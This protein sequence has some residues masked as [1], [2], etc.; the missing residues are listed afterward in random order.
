MIKLPVT[1][2]Q[3]DIYRFAQ[4]IRGEI[5]PQKPMFAELFLDEGMIKLIGEEFLG[6][7]WVAPK[8]DRE[9]KK[10]YW[11]FKIRVYHALGYDYL[12]MFGAPVFP[13]RPRSQK[14]SRVWAE[15]GKGPIQSFDDF[16]DYPWPELTD[17]MLW[18]YYYVSE[19]LPD[20]MGMFVANGD[21]FLEVVANILIGYE[22]MCMMLYDDEALLKAVIEKAGGIIYDACSKMIH[23]PKSAGVFIGDD[24]G[25]GTSMLFSPE[26]Y[27]EHILPW[28]KKLAQAVHDENQLYLLHSCG[29]NDA[30]MRDL[31]DD[32]KIDAKHSFQEGFY[33]VREYKQKYGSEVTLLG[34]VDVNLL[35]TLDEEEL[36]KYVRDILSACM[37][38]GRYMLGTGNSV[39]DYIPVKNY[40]AMLD[41]G[42]KFSL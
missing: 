18:D 20:G 10:K 24:M 42:L 14:G 16:Y 30:I 12:W 11:D 19:N 1:N 38:G 29:K 5:I 2:P 25:F 31:I 6:M 39:T 27:R 3:P 34:G 33:G 8:A 40:F 9:S 35:C 22:S 23:V 21:G 13:V 26:F 15:T 37:P 7:S 28:H 41:E 32:V 36:R 17:E 4:V